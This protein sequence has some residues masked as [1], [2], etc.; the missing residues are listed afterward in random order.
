L[1]RYEIRRHLAGSY[2]AGWRGDHAFACL[3]GCAQMA[4]VWGR[5]FDVVN[6]ARYLN[7]ALKINDFLLETV[8]LDS[9][10]G[11]IRG[12]IKGSHPIWGNYMTWR[13]PSW[14]VKFTLDALFQEEKAM[15]RLEEATGEH[16]HTV[17]ASQQQLCAARSSSA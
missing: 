5:L 14:A 9:T 11:G 1:C 3:T 13:Y 6:D 2:D 16:C 7:A 10:D 4:R 15:N 17:R 8:R 12:G